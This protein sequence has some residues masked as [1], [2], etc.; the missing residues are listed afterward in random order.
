MARTRFQGT[1]LAVN[2]FSATGTGKNHADDE[3]AD[4]CGETDLGCHDREGKAYA[5]H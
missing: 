5:K 2:C 1:Y 3:G 4:G